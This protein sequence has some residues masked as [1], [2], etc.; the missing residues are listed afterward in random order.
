MCCGTSRCKAH[1][2]LDKGHVVV[3]PGRDDAHFGKVDGRLDDR[4]LLAE[5]LDGQAASLGHLGGMADQAEAGDVGA[6]V[7]AHLHHHVLG[8]L[9]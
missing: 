6:G 4:D 2:V 3:G 9:V 7:C 8:V 5:Q 1:I